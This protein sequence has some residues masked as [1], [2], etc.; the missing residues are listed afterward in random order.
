MQ[1]KK[2][3]FKEAREKERGDRGKKES[4]RGRKGMREQDAGATV[5]KL[6]GINQRPGTNTQRLSSCVQ[7]NTLI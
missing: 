7:T 3:Y 4:A 2:A 6:G 5:M 1:E